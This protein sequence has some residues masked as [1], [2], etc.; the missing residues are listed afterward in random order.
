M[1]SVYSNAFLMLSATGSSMDADGLFTQR[2]TPSYQSFGYVHHNAKGTFYAFSISKQGALFPG[3]YRLLSD[4]PLSQYG[5]ALQERYLS[6]RILHFCSTQLM[7][8]CY[9]HFATEDGFRM[10]GRIDTLHQD[11]KPERTKQKLSGEPGGR[12]LWQDILQNYCRRTLSRPSD[13]LPALSNLARI[14]QEQTGDT[15]VAGLWRSKLMEGLI[16]QATG[17]A[18]G[19]TSEPPEYRAP[20]WSWASI[21]GPFGSFTLGLGADAGDWVELATVLNCEVALKG[22]NPYGGVASASLK[23][24]VP[25]EPL[26]LCLDKETRPQGQ[27][28]KTVNGAESGTYCIFDTRERKKSAEGLPMSV[29]VLVNGKHAG[30]ETGSYHGV[31]VVPVTEQEGVYRRV[32]KVAFGEAQLGECDWMKDDG[33]FSTITLV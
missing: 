23:L 21:D 8:E 24:R 25:L 13:K 32:G 1:A 19:M 5:W 6:P 10:Q 31:V 29:L 18:S 2:T 14:V 22:K 26:S 9:G 15:Y 30:C 7:F 12:R 4:E 16:W 3:N 20:S 27:W 28:M 33:N 17:H 11:T